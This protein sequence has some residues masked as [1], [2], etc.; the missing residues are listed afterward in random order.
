MKRRRYRVRI[1]PSGYVFI[2]LTIILSVGAVNTGNNLLYMLSSLLLGLMILSGLASLGNLLFL[3]TAL[4]PAPEVFAGL[5]ARF[6]LQIRRKR[7]RSFF[8]TGTTRYG[9]VRMPAVNGPL[10]APLWLSFPERGKADVDAVVLH[11]G[12]PLGFFR[13]FK[14]C[15]IGLEILVY[16]RPLPPSLPISRTGSDGHQK[17]HAR[18]GEKGDEIRELRGYRPSDPMRWV[19]WK[20]TA[21][22]GEM[23]VKEF[24]FLQGDSL[25]LDLSKKAGNWEA[26]LSAVCHLV[27]EGTRKDLLITLVL[28][29]RVLGPGR[30]VEHRRLLLEALA[31]A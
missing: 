27:L 22:R 20:A 18:E 28:P 11:S 9:S 4:V 3:D 8:L 6:L 5:P 15:S 23:V 25:V 31:L 14:T 29:D 12:F 10:V 2:V 17:P 21:R 1:T 13:R 16:P 19:D 30:G 26:R 7:G 24:Y